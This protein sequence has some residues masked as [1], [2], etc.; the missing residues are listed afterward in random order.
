MK[1][2][3]FAFLC[4]MMSLVSAHAANE[5]RLILGSD[6]VTVIP[7]DNS[8]KWFLCAVTEKNSQQLWFDNTNHKNMVALGFD[9]PTPECIYTWKVW[10]NAS[11]NGGKGFVNAKFGQ[12]TL[13]YDNIAVLNDKDYKGEQFTFVVAYVQATSDNFGY[14]I[15]SDLT[16][17]ELVYD[18]GF[19]FHPNW[20][21]NSEDSSFYFNPNDANVEYWYAVINE[22][23]RK[24]ST[25]LQIW[26]RAANPNAI[27]GIGDI[28]P[29][30]GYHEYID[31]AGYKG[32]DHSVIF[33]GIETK[34]E[35]LRTTRVPKGEVHRFTFT[36]DADRAKEKPQDTTIVVPETAVKDTLEFTTT[37]V[38]P[39]V[40]DNEGKYIYSIFS[41][42]GKWKVQINYD[43]AS[44]YGHITE[45]E[46][47]LSG[48]NA[49]YNYIRDAKNDQE[50]Y[51]FKK[52]EATVT[53]G[54]DGETQIEI[55]GLINPD[56]FHKDVFRRVLVHATLPAYTPKDTTVID[57][58]HAY[59]SNNEYL[60]MEGLNYYTIEA[61]SEGYTLLSGFFAK[62][63]SDGA[64]STRDLV[65]P[66]LIHKG[67]VNDTLSLCAACE[68]ILRVSHV[69][70]VHHFTYDI[71]SEDLHLYRV[72]FDDEVVKIEPKDTVLIQC[73][74]TQAT[75]LSDEYGVYT[76]FGENNTYQVTIAVKK[77]AVE[78]KNMV[79]SN[80]DIDFN[81]SLVYN[82]LTG[83]KVQLNSAT[84]T[85]VDNGDQT[86]DLRGDLIG[87]DEILYKVVM[88]IGYSVLPDDVDT[89][90]ITMKLGRI[91][92]ATG[93][94]GVVGIVGYTN[95]A[96]MHVYFYN[97]G[98]LEG[99]FKED[100]FFYQGNS[101]L[102]RPTET[103]YRFT[104]IT[105][106]NAE[107]TKVGDDTQM[108]FLLYTITNEMFRV[109]IDMP[110][111]ECLTK[112]KYSVD[113][114]DDVYM[115][116]I[117]DTVFPSGD[118]IFTVQ[119]Q[120]AEDF[121]KEGEPVGDQ[122][123]FTYQFITD[124]SLSLAGKF[125]Y[126]DTTLNMD[127]W[128]TIIEKNIELYVG[129]MAGTLEIVPEDVVAL[130]YGGQRYQS[131][132][133]TISSSFVGENGLVYELAGQ[134]MVIAIDG[135]GN[136]LTLREDLGEEGL[137]ITDAEGKVVKKQLINGQLYIEHAGRRYTVLGQ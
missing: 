76:Y 134:N 56:Y 64:Y 28:T 108:T 50:V 103:G 33:A 23:N 92:Y 69:D 115:V 121:T 113:Y 4:V 110:K 136:L 30:K 54:A 38:L 62:D 39:E 66:Y 109:S 89:V 20:Y 133:Y 32:G 49:Y 24:D 112:E 94:P 124:D 51:H 128:H 137:E 82:V 101:Y 59:V 40:S 12:L 70:A 22:K 73:Y 45:K 16:M 104:N 126:N 8:K 132:L 17:T 98:K 86:Y 114:M 61:H 26:T 74:N 27:L 53:E 5:F 119:L 77:S 120:Y 125:A 111:L 58:G 81:Y 42:E 1:K 48:E 85:L 46:F 25:D 116:A 44:R 122:F 91:D 52:L 72:L 87:R 3:V 84:A 106:A 130:N 36:P 80:S 29:L 57:M 75:D 55:N 123:Y 67:L 90:D 127:R 95:E 15:T 71:I 6:E 18:P 35:G 79:Y 14:E 31:L 96:E 68:H 11:K 117:R 118:A 107:L 83:D 47:G 100:R 37:D 21:T 19:T 129:P 105:W 34:T 13:K 10:V 78:N 2:I 99:E 60:S 65:K 97:T 63:L 9:S 41:L 131:Y 43:A 88:P 102:T 135:Q 7:N 93:T